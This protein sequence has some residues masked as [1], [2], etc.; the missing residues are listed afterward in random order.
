MT[1]GEL[2]G[3][4]VAIVGLAG[5]FPGAKN[6][7]EYWQHLC[8]GTETIS[9]FSEDE[10]AA[11]GVDAHELQ[12]PAY[13]RRGGVV[14]DIDLFDA[15]FFGYSPREAAF[16]DPQQRL[17][18]ECAEEALENA[19]YDARS[20]G[21]AIGVYA[22][23][24][25]NT[26]LLR[27]L[28]HLQNWSDSGGIFQLITAN[29]K[30]FLA[31]R[32]AY[33]L[34]LRGPAL[35][36]QTACS[37]SL[38]AVHLAVRAL[39]GGECSMALAGG[40]T[41]R[42]PQKVGYQYQEGGIL[43][44][45]GHC[46]AFDADAQGTVAS[47]GV[48]IVVLK[49]LEDA[50]ADRDHIYAVIKGS[51]INNDGSTK[52]GYTAPGIQG[53]ARVIQDAQLVSEMDVESIGYIETHGT[54]TI[55]GDP[56]EI[57]ALTEAFRASTDK[58]NFCAIGS[59]KE[60]IGHL[61]TASGVAGLIKAAYSLK[62][63]VLVPSVHFKSPNAALQLENS[64]FYVNTELREWQ[65]EN[66]LPRRAGIS[67][68]GIGG[69]NAHVLLEE[70]PE[71]ASSMRT[72]RPR[73]VVMLSARTETAL[74]Q[75]SVQLAAYVRQHPE[76]ELADIAYTLQVGRP[77]FQ[78][79]QAL[80]CRDADDLARKLE[81]EDAVQLMRGVVEGAENAVV[82][83]FPGQGAQYIEM[84]RD[85]YQTEAVFRN[86][87]ER[88]AELLRP[89]L[90]IDLLQVLY[91][92]PEGD[93]EQD[94]WRLTQTWLTQPALFAVEYALAKQWEAWGVHPSAMIGHS[95]GE[96]V[97]ACLAGVFS[98]EDALQLVAARGRLMQQLPAGA[99]LTV[100]LPAQEVQAFLDDRLSIAAINTQTQCVVSGPT[101]AVESLAR[102][103]QIRGIDCRRLHTSHA[104]HSLMVDPIIDEFVELVRS[105]PLHPP[106]LPY[107]SNVTGTWISNVQACD[108]LYWGH[109]MRQPV[110]F[111]TG[112]AEILHEGSP[113]LL[114]VGPGRTLSTF[115]RQQS[116]ALP[117]QISHTIIPS[118]RRPS[119]TT[120]D[121]EFMLT[122]LGRLWLAGVSIAWDEFHAGELCRRVPLP[123]Y[124]FER[125]RYWIDSV[126][127]ARGAQTQVIPSESEAQQPSTVADADTTLY[128]RPVLPTRYIAPRTQLE[129]TLATLW[130]QLLGVAQIG[131]YDSFFEL[132]GHSLL[133]TQL[134][135][136]LRSDLQVSLPLRAIFEA[137]T[138]AE[139]SQRIEESSS[140]SVDDE[141]LVQPIPV[142]TREDR[143]PLSYAQKRLWF[144]QQM[145]QDAGF[146]NI[147]L[148]L[149]LRGPLDLERLR[150]C[151]QEIVNRHETLR[152]TFVVHA[153]EPEPLIASTLPVM[154]EI[155]DVQGL[156]GSEQQLAVQ[157][158]STQKVRRAFDLE[159]GPLF[160]VTVFKL[161]PQEHVLLVAM[162]HSISDGWSFSILVRE[163]IELY[164][165]SHNSQPSSLPPLAVQYVD[166]A[167][168]QQQWLQGNEIERQL[169]YWRKQLAGP[170]PVLELPT[171][172]PRPA[173]QTYRGA[174]FPFRLPG[175]LTESI[176][177]LSQQ[178]GATLFMLLLAALQIVCSRYSGQ[179]DILIGTPIAN[180]RRSEIEK[181][182][183][184]FI[185]TLV[186]RTQLS[187]SETF[188]ELLRS[189]REKVLEAYANQDLPFEQ[190][191]EALQPE[192]D[193]SRSPIFQVMFMLQ[194]VP[195]PT[196]EFAGLHL[197]LLDIDNGATQFDLTFI[198]N[199]TEE[200]VAGLVEYNVDLFEEETIRRM[201]DH[202]QGVLMGVTADCTRRIADVPLFTTAEREQLSA[203]NDTQM[204]WQEPDSLPQLFAAQVARTPDAVAL[205]WGQT[206][207]TY[208][209]LNK[210]A[211][212]VAH[213]LRAAGVGPG[214]L[215]G[216]CLERSAE[217]VVA[218][219]GVLKAG[220]AYVPLDPAYPQ[221]RL[222]YMLTN[223]QAVALLIEEA[224]VECFPLDATCALV[225]LPLAAND[226]ED[227][228]DPDVELSAEDLAYVIYTSGSTGKPKGV[229]ISHRAL[230][231][232]F[233]SMARQPGLTGA[234]NV[235]AVT[236]FSF[237]IAGLELLL[238]LVVGAAITIVSQPDAMDAFALHHLLE[239]TGASF[240]QATPATWRLLLN[241]GWQGSS[242]LKILC[243][244]EALPWEL[245]QQLCQRSDSVW[246]MYGPTET[247]IWSTLRPLHTNEAQI[248]IGWPIANTQVYVLDRQG[249]ELPVG[250]AG[251]LFIGGEGM[252]HGY[253]QLP[254]L[255]A[256]RFV[257][258][259]FNN[260][261][262]ARLYRTG[263]LVRRTADG[264]L[265]Y[266]NR[267]DFQVKVRGHRIELGE[268]ETRLAQHPA[269]RECV[270]VV[271]EEREGDAR[272]VAYMVPQPGAVISQPELRTFMQQH[273]PEYMVPS[274]FV[275]LERWP[276]TPN[277][278]IDRRALPI[279]EFSGSQTHL[280]AAPTSP[281]EEIVV[282]VWNRILQRKVPGTRENFFD[283][284]GH[285]LLATQLLAQI[286]ELFSI[287]I[288]LRSVFEAPTVK[289]FAA[290]LE[291]VLRQDQDHQVAPIVPVQRE[292]YLP[293]SFAQQ[294]LWLLE[295]L[296][297]DTAAYHIPLAVRLRGP[298]DV[299][300]LEQ[301]LGE[302]IQRHESLRTVFSMQDGQVKQTILPFSGFTLS[303]IHLSAWDAATGEQELQALVRA[304][305][306]K[307]FDVGQ[308]PLV[309]ATLFQKQEEEYVLL[310]T[311]HHIVS[312]G[313]SCRVLIDELIHY[314]TAFAQGD[315]PALAPLSIQYADFA[316][317]QRQWLSGERR[318]VQLQYWKQQLANL[319]LLELPT[320]HPRPEAQTF[321][322]AD[323]V[324]TLPQS[325]TTAL[326]DISQ[327][328]GVTLFMTMLA[329]FQV[330]LYAYTGQD[331]ITVG[332]P[333]T[334]RSHAEL[335]GLIGFFVNT[336]VLRTSLS[337]N[338]SFT[339]LLARV[340]EVC[341]E[342]YTHQDLPFEQIVDAVQ[343]QRDLSRSPLFQVMFMLQYLPDVVSS[344]QLPGLQLSPF[345][346]G[347]Q[348]AKFD[349]TL[350]LT[351]T[352]QHIQAR[353]EYAT[354]LF[355]AQTIERM[356]G[357]WQTLLEGIVADP[358]TR[359]ASLP[360]LTAEEY[361]LCINDW[362]KTRSSYPEELCLPQ[363]FEAQV[364]STPDHPAAI[365][366][367]EQLSYRELNRRA[368]Q[369]AH[370]LQKLGVGPDVRVGLYL[371]P[372]LELLIAIL[373][374]LKA[375][376]GYVSIDLAYPRERVE[377]LLRDASVAALLTQE[378]HRDRI[379]V[380]DQ[381]AQVI[382]FD[383]IHPELGLQSVDNPESTV[384][385]DNLAYILYT[386]GSTGVPKGVMIPHRGLANYLQWCRQRYAVAEGSG[387]P[388]H[389]SLSFDL[390]VTSL[391]SPLLSG[392]TAVLLP[393]EHGVESLN[394]AF[395][396]YQNFSLVK[397]TP[398]HLA[399]LGLQ[400]DLGQY[401]AST[402]LFV[403]GGEQLLGEK[404]AFWQDLAPE[405][406]FINE[407]GPTETVV[408]CCIYQVPTGQRIAGPVPIGRPIANTQLYL[409]NQSLQPVPIGIP[410]ELYIGGDGLARGYLNQPALTAER[411]IPNPFSPQGGTRLYKTGDLARYRADGILE[412][413]GR[414]DHQV[415]VRGFRIELGEIEAVLS[416]HPEIR[417][418]AVVVQ[419]DRPD[420][421]RLVAYVVS[422]QADATLSQTQ[423]R[424]YVQQHLPEYMT[425]AVFVQLARLP[426]T[427]NGKLDREALPAPG[428]IEHEAG[429][430]FVA[431]RTP[432]EQTL[433]RI[434][435]EV[436]GMDRVSVTDNFFTLGG[437]SLLSMQIIVRAAQAHLRLTPRQIFQQQTVESLASVVN[438]YS[439]FQAEQGIVEGPVALTPIQHWFFAQ[440]LRQPYHW[441]QSA[442]LQL[443]GPMN[444]GALEKA[445]EILFTH[446][447][448]LRMRF[449]QRNGAWQQ[450]NA[451][452]KNVADFFSYS[453]LAGQPRVDQE[454]MITATQ[455][456]IQMGFEL[457]QGPLL[458]AVYFD[459]G[460]EQPALLLICIHHLVVDNVS[461]Q[462]LLTDLQAAYEAFVRNEQPQLPP[463]T[464]S[465]Q[466]WAEQLEQY[467]QSEEV[468]QEQAFWLE[469]NYGE[470]PALPLDFPA[471]AVSNT[472]DSVRTY[473][474]SLS[475]EETRELQ[476][477]VSRAY[478]FPM[479]D[480]VLAMLAL[481]CMRW[482]ESDAIQIDTEGHGREEIS[483]TI[484]VSRTVG[485]FTS[486][487]PIYLQLSRSSS[488]RDALLRLQEKL[489]R[490]P[491]KG[492]N[493][494]ALR[495]L[496]A[497]P[498]LK[499]RFSALPRADILLNYVG[500]IDQMIASA[501]LF[502]AIYPSSEF[503][504]SPMD[505]RPYLF[506]IISGIRDGKFY[507]DW[508]Y[509]SQAHSPSTIE[510][511][512]SDF[513][514]AV[515]TL[516]QQHRLREDLL[517]GPGVARVPLTLE[518]C[519][520]L[521]TGLAVRATDI[522]TIDTLSPAQQGM[523]YET[524]SGPGT[525]IH[526]E[527]WLSTVTGNLQL[528]A[529]Q[530]AWQRV[531]D[532]HTIFR[533]AFAWDTLAE[534]VQVTLR[535]AT[536]PIQ[537]YDLSELSVEEQAVYI[538]N[539][540]SADRLQGFELA[541]AP[542]MR[543]T[544]FRLAADHY[545]FVLT[546][547]HML[548]DL[549]C[550][551]LVIQEVFS[552]YQ[553]YCNQQSLHL[554][555][556]LPYSEYIAWLKK[557]NIAEAERFWRRSLEGFSTPTP[558]GRTGEPHSLSGQEATHA[559]ELLTLPAST[560]AAV[561]RV[562]RQHY[563]TLN[564]L[565]QGIWALLLSRYADTEDVLFGVTVAGR[566]P[567]LAGIEN[568]I[569]L[570]I[571]TLPLRIHV[572]PDT[573]LWD[574]L[575][576]IQDYNLDLRQYEYTPAGS[577]HTWSDVP[578]GQPLYESL[579]VVENFPESFFDF[580]TTIG[581]VTLARPELKGAQTQHALTMLVT[582]EAEL[583]IGCIYDRQR[584]S[585][586]MAQRILEHFRLLLEQLV[587][588]SDKSLTALRQL[589]TDEQIP[590]I[591]PAARAPEWA[592]DPPRTSMEHALASIWQEV[593]GVQQIGIH[594]NFF[595]LG[596][597]SLLATQL[598]S[599]IRTKLQI[600]LP[601]RNL[602]EYPTIAM[603][604]EQLTRHTETPGSHEVAAIVPVAS[605][606][607]PL[608]LAQQRLWFL[609]QLLP[610]TS[611]YN[612]TRSLRIHGPL[613]AVCLRRSLEE[614]MRRHAILRTTFHSKGGQP[615]QVID[616][617]VNLNWT[618][619]DLKHDQEALREAQA[620]AL[621]H[622]EA[623]QPM[624]LAHG[625][626]IRAMLLEL[627]AE[628]AIL[629]VSIHHIVFD[630]WSEGIFIR[631][632]MTLYQAFAAGQPSPLP[633][634]PIQYAD[635]AV[636]QR[637]WL[638]GTV[639]NDQIGYWQK[640]LQNV[641]ELE[642]PTDHPRQ[643]RQ[644]HKGAMK[645][646]ALDKELSAALIG[647]SRQEGVTVFMT[648]LTSYMTLLLRY[649]GQTDIVVGTDIANRTRT[650]T[651]QLIGFFVNLLVLRGDLSRNPR[652]VD[653]L[654]QIR[655]MV[656]DA[657]AH[658]DL[659]FEKL[660]DVLHL[661]REGGQ[662]PLV[663]T[664]FVM[665]NI[666]WVAPD[667]DDIT[668]TPVP[669]EQDITRFDLAFF[670][671][672]TPEGFM[673]TVNYSTELFEEKT[674]ATMI[675][676]FQMLLQSICTQPDTQLD[677]LKMYSAEAETKKRASQ[678]SRL[679]K[680][681]REEI[682]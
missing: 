198:V 374:I 572:R 466:R 308:L 518:Q 663:R 193:L 376:G 478:H 48:G 630:V 580:N 88:C 655:Q 214:K 387:A 171:D 33:K 446:H 163:L 222:N 673:G 368:N 194:N 349:L 347:S 83:M 84:G 586:P 268:I 671:W 16:L 659:P 625:P 567:E 584:I 401:A 636:W 519:E 594:V 332:T 469:E 246:N 126:Q 505:R 327:R 287:E 276:L 281:I 90:G 186:I 492:F 578:G 562:A 85:L 436:L 8:E 677:A 359:I 448:A 190:V 10:L 11:E 199:E 360:L 452:Q 104:F 563:V 29:D 543:L 597:H 369:L 394:A 32:V 13:V 34:N 195:I 527:Q 373:A 574:W 91:P 679:K 417:E 658:Q 408:G 127:L 57:A 457:D 79:R 314:Y 210:A 379:P 65:T 26:Y 40:V 271:R 568:M 367:D 598:I 456:L 262:G 435:A 149:R 366:G 541:H 243:G 290:L 312:D 590:V 37:T 454:R 402:R 131:V 27:N 297:P 525:G 439:P 335:E 649:T 575:P 484:D 388:V 150:H 43:S 502:T 429:K 226:G 143:L 608:S 564:T 280:I 316:S 237:D 577:I 537:H 553:A 261:P 154:L 588:G 224:F 606:Q 228:D 585:Q 521:L 529:F 252:A 158:L 145:E 482:M 42:V 557:Q 223:S 551:H 485:W 97:A 17:F 421:Q 288:P 464:T 164:T 240:M 108:P 141:A 656:L 422:R 652:F 499:R 418:C 284:G 263:D 434:W 583:G 591:Y 468:M 511:L 425:P 382:A 101:D 432:T 217:L 152:T 607:V 51:A 645:E 415:K 667:L 441:N 136:R 106:R 24:G 337:N 524:L 678:L 642:I 23:A 129:Q 71:P 471:D 490:L 650:E 355:E 254:A 146:L 321:R 398:A 179:E 3:L 157:Q 569:G 405:M 174:H 470:V 365:F 599:R 75:A 258:D 225:T 122:G 74:Q 82:F 107:I 605:D 53:Q 638:Q 550:H 139:L 63:R 520:Q 6:V 302:I 458:Q 86:A 61:D 156:A 289:E 96:Y 664:L 168:W 397:I 331:D 73:K 627:S 279:P 344:F 45:D 587:S 112:I 595:E 221:E 389:S 234:D 203:W 609:D 503:D 358:T 269:V 596:G 573:P 274:H 25:L 256:E 285:S 340:R 353:L 390:T 318:D 310:V 14:E 680:A 169:G 95:I 410:G 375:G 137:T 514:Q 56:I 350:D 632:L 362:N 192:R 411:F 333:V 662:T 109:H 99:M 182:I 526:V 600:D 629:V 128:P 291:R 170:L 371:E 533:T 372:S 68:F 119:E 295:Q 473:S 244:G 479:N 181:L 196:S 311:M 191:V 30:D 576:A 406:Q 542:L 118:L 624:N 78:Y 22:G 236:S 554:E 486:I 414:N 616:P 419:V 509:S 396:T 238:P 552:H 231:N 383:T 513:M 460:T 412:F 233:L 296:S 304:E 522:E 303:S 76:F 413:L 260:Q 646:F 442:L 581:N 532:R 135:S 480:I 549:W 681:K 476:E 455:A 248:S 354:D 428:T 444:G 420:V 364:E 102:R 320:D 506:E 283:L 325:L 202:W 416:Q 565:F 670:M 613:Q 133:A 426:L 47:N 144:M 293:A 357:H 440:Q 44:P 160:R 561:Q 654:Q 345:P 77:L 28:A 634:L 275:Q 201:V 72:F 378:R 334:N 539:Y 31:S 651:E 113:I 35:A 352:E 212:Q 653:V 140:A 672:E 547:H 176:K 676:H 622:E 19:G 103:L 124:P 292:R 404:L 69:T 208:A 593:L 200:C 220:G 229:M 682:F 472:M 319:V 615:I 619:I 534:P 188:Q 523:L 449:T 89:H 266:L 661:E 423:L 566:P 496:S 497:D 370:Y 98:L 247:T 117:Q 272:L 249:R 161:A 87:I 391:F 675:S 301:G 253:W 125:H 626:L 501:N 282:D 18:L 162:H 66:D 507:I 315:L 380:T 197:D 477:N 239:M 216:I 538:E 278:K 54:G 603:L 346:I 556:S 517:I 628:D 498:S 165:A 205:V 300:A 343:P 147:P 336:L 227:I 617:H 363:L 487:Y 528:E 447:D 535:N 159:H 592:L 453:D 610:D 270:A 20:Y 52:V 206:F 633:A 579:L 298:L 531:I 21:E 153:G 317:W 351:V 50:L 121:D 465:Y 510:R 395:Q 39:V 7:E 93:R 184:C 392:Q 508:K 462:I 114:E 120:S 218:M 12:D 461:W 614:I 559:S 660:I 306:M 546:Y 264:A 611:L 493:Y 488:E 512:A 589:I 348:A 445:F 384:C 437:D 530:Q 500:Q 178:E 309:R 571:N 545:R 361:Q 2:N 386:S 64:P 631:E 647:L 570:C 94:S 381:G 601:L 9:S 674:I 409:L 540:A 618:V 424:D 322:G 475:Q 504:R 338:P 142:L 116:Q 130:Q 36:V 55:N 668:L 307:P 602:F 489:R 299:A 1:N 189:I 612:I 399:L 38:V 265:I 166:F 46:R 111:A 666:P 483:E 105:I 151:L 604:A 560:T 329:S 641:R 286:R 640:Q 548:M 148:G 326:Q 637:Q 177:A 558:L 277:G 635:F 467:A 433:A 324:F 665:Q 209:G 250:V 341:L 620:I 58:K 230:R 430:T 407:Y 257:P 255:T 443:A 621:M 115:A 657:Y 385:P 491:Q 516:M 438:T 232:C 235:L 328:E 187:G 639:L 213:R 172:H 323:R 180:R 313:P 100:S 123:T 245:A 459:R 450:R 215:V 495:Y 644:G 431:P 204:A 330:L 60:N 294:R 183:G 643:A 219:L 241:A 377:F 134:V 211:N 305:I 138:V 342:S 70:A 273:L 167:A 582:V 49:R 427:V 92:A 451:D 515:R 15:A 207:W 259:P 242:A 155:E 80:V 356:I 59:V 393:F 41:L 339:E 5:R 474:L 132:G 481:T 175:A 251:E 494:G 555:P 4:E 536:L 648:L 67:S 81:A 623:H 403:I 185:N 173:I 267:S 544:L 110:H 463:K 400:P 669:V 62:H